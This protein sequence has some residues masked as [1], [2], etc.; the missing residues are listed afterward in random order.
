MRGVTGEELKVKGDM[1]LFVE[2][3]G[4]KYL[5]RSIVVA[6]GYEL[7]SGKD[8]RRLG[9][10]N[11]HRKEMSKYNMDGNNY[12][13]SKI[14]VLR[15]PGQEV[16]QEVPVLSPVLVGETPLLSVPAVKEALSADV[17]EVDDYLIKTGILGEQYRLMVRS[18]TRPF[19]G[20][21]RRV[22]F[23]M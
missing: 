7:L 5:A 11:L 22:P 21:A 3:M 8:A 13:M 17:Y 20:H 14:L 23:A 19:I 15:G 12:F 10:L 1:K 4:E 9:I 16:T 2:Y 18:G 6:G